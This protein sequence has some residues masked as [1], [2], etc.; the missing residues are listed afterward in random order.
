MKVVIAPDSFKEC[1]PAGEAAAALAAGVLDA[2][3]DAVVDLCPMADGGEGTVDAMVAAAGGKVLTA[4]VFDPLGAPIRARFALLGASADVPLPGQ[5]GLVAALQRAEGEEAPP[6]GAVA[7]IEMASASGLV[8]VGPDRRDPLRATTYGTGQLII[9]ALDSGA[10]QIIVGLGGSGTTDGGCGC[11][12]AMGVEF[13]GSGGQPAIC[14]LGGGGLIDIADFDI[15]T[16]DARLAE[17]CLHV[18]C[19]VRNPLLGPS[20]AAAVYAPQKGATEEMVGM[21]E[22]GLSHLAALIQSKLGMDVTL[23]PGAGAAGGLGAGLVAF[24]DAELC[25]G[26]DLVGETVGLK[27]RLHDADMCITGEGKLD[28]QSLA[29]KVAVSVATIAGD[30]G[31]ATICIPGQAAVDAPGEVFRSVRPLV[32]G[33]VTVNAAMTQTRGLLQQRAAE[34]VKDFMKP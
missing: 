2:C 25:N 13:T 16:R 26:F 8:L 19:D 28:G 33:S 12:Q 30:L 14:G 4:D 34:A 18:A 15:A 29:G 11:A 5:L 1:L 22:A 7:V 3:P 20:G 32:A 10:R 23:L 17:A 21:L 9:A 6:A 31:V 27:K 24:A